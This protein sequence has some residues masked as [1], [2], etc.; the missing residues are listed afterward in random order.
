MAIL[1]NSNYEETVP[2]SDVNA[3]LAL[4]TNTNLAYTVPGSLTDTYQVRFTYLY[5]SNVFVRMNAAATVPGAGLQTAV[6]Y[7][8]FRPGSDGSKRYVRGTETINFITPDAS[9]Y[10]GIVLMSIPT[11]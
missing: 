6:Q 2:F 7:E 4:A 3:Q 10:V 5:N 11:Q 9:A 8:E 1:I